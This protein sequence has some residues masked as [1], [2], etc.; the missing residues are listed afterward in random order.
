MQSPL[1]VLEIGFLPNVDAARCACSGEGLARAVAGRRA[2]FG[3][4]AADAFG[5]ARAAGGDEVAVRVAKIGDERGAAV[6]GHVEDLGGGRYQVTWHILPRSPHSN[7]AWSCINRARMISWHT[8]VLSRITCRL[9][10]SRG[11]HSTWW[12]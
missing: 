8:M 1:M 9:Q 10:S 7:H 12:L 4:D 2:C 5:N 6:A 11:A 3:V